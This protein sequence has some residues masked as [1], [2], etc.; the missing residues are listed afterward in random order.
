[1]L[2]LGGLRLEASEQH[3]Q[4]APLPLPTVK[5]IAQALLLVTSPLTGVVEPAGPKG[6]SLH[7]GADRPELSSR[8]E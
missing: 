6:L 3:L 2:A 7:G 8:A 5:Q 1:M 4:A